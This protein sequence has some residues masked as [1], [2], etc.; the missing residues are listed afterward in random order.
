MK[1]NIFSTGLLLLVLT[2]LLLV[3]ISCDEDEDNIKYKG[4]IVLSS[5]KFQNGEIYIVYGFAF[6]KGENVPYTLTGGSPPD[7]IVSNLTDVLNNITGGVLNSPNNIEAFFL[8]M[9]GA[10]Y[11]EAKDFFDSYLEVTA[12]NFEAISDSVQLYQ[13]W[14]VQ[15]TSGKFAKLL[16]KG[17]NI[18]EEPLPPSPDDYMEIT[19]DYEY[20]PD[21]TRTFDSNRSGN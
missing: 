15:T 17:I 9:T 5:E 6:E 7:I 19:V 3:A 4:E 14:T 18:I 1:G 2:S 10:N 11:A 20:Q 16:I 8:N 12:T 13:V 21:G